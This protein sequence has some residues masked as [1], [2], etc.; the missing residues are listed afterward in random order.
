MVLLGIDPGASGGVAMMSDSSANVEVW[1]M[2]WIT[3]V[4]INPEPLRTWLLS[5]DHVFIEALVTMPTG[6]EG[7]KSV[8]TTVGQWWRIHG[9]AEMVQR[10]I[11]IVQ[12]KAWQ[13]TFGI[14]NKDKTLR[15]AASVAVAQRLFPGCSF[16][17]TERCKKPSDGMA[18]AVLICEHGRR[19]SKAGTE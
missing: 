16:M 14:A 7:A 12:S 8:R 9:M 19:T 17:P 3:G 2:P 10:P 1:P 6:K 13:K 11:T 18:E 15:K 4:G 5:A